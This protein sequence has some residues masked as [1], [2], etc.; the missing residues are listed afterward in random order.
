MAIYRIILARGPAPGRGPVRTITVHC[1][2]LPPD[3]QLITKLSPDCLFFPRQGW[4]QT[5]Y[6]YQQFALCNSGCSSLWIVVRGLADG[7]ELFLL[8]RLA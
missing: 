4:S 7:R 6:K 5:V 1:P 3:T 2:V 8:V